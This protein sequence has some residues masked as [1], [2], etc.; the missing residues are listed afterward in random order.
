MAIRK[1]KTDLFSPPQL[2][3]TFHAIL[4]HRSSLVLWLSPVLCHRRYDSWYR[5]CLSPRGRITAFS[6]LS[7]GVYTPRAPSP[8]RGRACAKSHFLLPDRGA[9]LGLRLMF[10]G[11]ALIEQE[12]VSETRNKSDCQDRPS[13]SRGLSLALYG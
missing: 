4:H 6:L 13:L 12:K 8:A 1:W 5:E 7:L 9:V 3:C 10:G 11:G 2:P